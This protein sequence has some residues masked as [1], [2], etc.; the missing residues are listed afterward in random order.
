MNQKKIACTITVIILFA[1]ILFI[2]QRKSASQKKE[3]ATQAEETAFTV[4]T[5]K[6]GRIDFSVYI[7]IN[8]NVEANNT[9]SVYP[10]MNGKMIRPL[11]S[12]GSKVRKGDV[13]AEI[14]PS[15][16]GEPYAAS[17]VYAP[18]SG[19]ITSVPDRKSVV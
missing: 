16:P 8:G 10:D 12:L 15:K 18:I 17:R 14:D 4:K 3:A 1:G 2:K 19:S 7:K 11:V 9:V 5:E 6:A 13:I